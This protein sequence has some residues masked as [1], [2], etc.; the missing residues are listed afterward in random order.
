MPAM[1]LAL[2]LKAMRLTL[3]GTAHNYLIPDAP[4]FTGNYAK[5]PP[6]SANTLKVVTFNIRNAQKIKQ[7]VVELREFVELRDADI[8]LLQ[9]MD[10]Q[11]SDKIAQALEYNYIYYPALM[12]P[13]KNRY[14]GNA[15][16][17]KWP[18]CE[19]AKILLPH[20]NPV[21]KQRRIAVYAT[22]TINNQAINIYSVHIEPLWLSRSKRVDQVNAL[23]NHI[24][25]R[26][27]PSPYIIVGG[28]F[29][30]LMGSEIETFT[31][32]FRTAGLERHTAGVGPT[33]NVFGVELD[34]IYT[35]GMRAIVAGKVEKSKASN[36]F[37]VW[38]K[39]EK[40][41]PLLL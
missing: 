21:N 1:V 5:T 41:P 33:Y 32:R 20:E 29:N 37:P 31:R 19:T 4:K 17:T 2:I 34:H 15:I 3:Y 18:I 22:I 14:V 12:N 25:E 39:L 40:E 30:T 23:I 7:A 36:H 35:K 24:L 38:V 9:E 10:N 13:R 26:D 8:L 16:L 28:D 6:S 27:T 11:G